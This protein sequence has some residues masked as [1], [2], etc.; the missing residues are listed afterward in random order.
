MSIQI[1]GQWADRGSFAGV[2]RAMSR[3]IRQRRIEGQ[4]YGIGGRDPKYFDT[5]LPVG[6]DSRAGI[7]LC[8]AYPETAPSWLAG[9]ECKILVTVCETDRVP[10]T[11][12]QACNAMD[13]IVVPSTWC[14]DAFVKSGVTSEIMIV[15]HG[16]EFMGV[17][18]K[19]ERY[20][21]L[22][23]HVSGSLTFAGRKGTIP[24]LRAFKEL[25]GFYPDAKLL[26][27]VPHTTGY[28]KALRLL[29][30]NNDVVEIVGEC[31]PDEMLAMDRQVDA[32]VQPSRAEGFGMCPLEARCVGTP[33]IITA[34]TGHAEYFDEALDVLIET[35]KPSL[36]ETQA[37][38]VGAAPSVSSKA[39]LDA[40][41][42]FMGEREARVEAVTAWA[43]SGAP[44]RWSWENTLAPL[45]RRIK[46]CYAKGGITLGAKSSLRGT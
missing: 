38:P 20:A 24:L 29:G 36:L 8:V 5:Y 12:A 14:R 19:K 11:W 9:H 37:N 15:N 1:Y 45:A 10:S 4:V 35:G 3:M 42:R 33:A 27:K 26:L 21:P 22:F 16:V 17:L 31:S 23:L 40:L 18:P 43:K 32:V 46:A 28:D 25:L 34:V 30:L 7:G 13:L 41:H 39:V 44:T 2:S 6:L